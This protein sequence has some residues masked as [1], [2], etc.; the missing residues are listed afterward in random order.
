M[1]WNCRQQNAGFHLNDCRFFGRSQ[2]L[3]QAHHSTGSRAARKRCR[4][5]GG[6]R[7]AQSQANRWTGAPWN[8]VECR[9]MWSNCLCIQIDLK[10]QCRP[11]GICSQG[12]DG[13]GSDLASELLASARWHRQGR[14]RTE[15]PG[16][17][18]ARTSAALA[19]WT[20]EKTNVEREEKEKI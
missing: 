6:Q 12:D 17:H 2:R 20:V 1:L 18:D 4:L 15:L 13:T 19:F 10:L 8:V 16:A 11:D 5:N 14:Y 9:G 3:V 7:L